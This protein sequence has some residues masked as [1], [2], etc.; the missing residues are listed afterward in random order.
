MNFARIM[1]IDLLSKVRPKAEHHWTEKNNQISRFCPNKTV[2]FETKL[3]NFMLKYYEKN[4]CFFQKTIINYGYITRNY[5]YI[6]DKLRVDQI[7]GYFG[8]MVTG[9]LRL[10][11]G[12]YDLITKKHRFVP[13]IMGILSYRYGFSR[14]QYGRLWITGEL[15]VENSKS[16][17]WA[18]F[19]ELDVVK[20]LCCF[21]FCRTTTV[22][23][24][25]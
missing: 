19:F 3:S 23:N 16:Y 11:M 22:D 25:C 1:A 6:T 13:W 2:K 14:P 21:H 4:L 20:L 10:I 15:W 8:K 24:T 5:G 12:G 7:T 17:V 9:S 18:I